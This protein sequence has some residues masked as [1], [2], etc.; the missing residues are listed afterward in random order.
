MGEQW[1]V[2]EFNSQYGILWLSE[3][4]IHYTL[5]VTCEHLD[6]A[7]VFGSRLEAQLMASPGSSIL[8]LDFAK[9]IVAGEL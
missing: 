2:A 9:A 5:N 4:G 3:V 7:K 6:N 1:V 8:T